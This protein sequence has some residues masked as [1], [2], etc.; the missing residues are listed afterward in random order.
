MPPVLTGSTGFC[1]S[2]AGSE[3]DKLWDGKHRKNGF[4]RH[5]DSMTPN[6][7]KMVCRYFLGINPGKMHCPRPWFGLCVLAAWL[8]QRNPHN[9]AGAENL[10]RSKGK[11]PTGTTPRI[12]LRSRQWVDM[13]ASAFDTKGSGAAYAAPLP[14][15]QNA[16]GIRAS[17]AIS[18]SSGLS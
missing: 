4:C 7:F 15:K 11:A 16:F 5:A 12:Q 17:F 1:R 10:F 2:A 14:L 8:R 18:A 13:L 3:S 9:N 6:P